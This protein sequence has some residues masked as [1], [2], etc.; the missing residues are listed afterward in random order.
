MSSVLLHLALAIR[1]LLEWLDRL[2]FVME[3]RHRV[4]CAAKCVLTAYLVRAR[5]QDEGVGYTWVE[6]SDSLRRLLG[7]R[8]WCTFRLLLCSLGGS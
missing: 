8:T 6:H 1:V 3:L 2:G 4:V 7:C 5:E